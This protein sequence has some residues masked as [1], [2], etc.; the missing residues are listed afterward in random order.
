MLVS[1][2]EVQIKDV[3]IVGLDSKELA[4]KLSLKVDRFGFCETS[5]FE[6]NAS[7]RP[8]IYVAGAFER[9]MDIPESVMNASSAAFMA[10]KSIA[11]ARGSMVTE[12]EYPS[13]SARVR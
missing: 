2:P 4:K 7:S 1:S 8:G 13:A 6:P 11:E 3:G 9:P 10:S 12:K 5:E